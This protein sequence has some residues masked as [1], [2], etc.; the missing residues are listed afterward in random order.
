MAF[1]ETLLLD[2]GSEAALFTLFLYFLCQ[3]MGGLLC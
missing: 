1:D 2:G 3:F